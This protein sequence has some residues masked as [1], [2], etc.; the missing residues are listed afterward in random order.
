[1]TAIRNEGRFNPNTTLIDAELF[2]LKGVVA[3]FLIESGDQKILIDTGAKSSGAV[4]YRKLKKLNAWP[5]NKIILTHSH[6]DHTQGVI[7]LRE[8]AEEEGFNIEVMASEKGIQYLKNQKYNTF[9]KY[10]DQ[11]PFVNINK[12]KPLRDGDVIELSDEFHLKIFETPGHMVDDICLYDKQNKCVFV[13]DCVG[14]KQVD[15]FLICNANSPHWDEKAYHS[16]VKKLKTLN[17]ETLC[18]SHFGCITGDEAKSFLDESL[19]IF[20]KWKG[21]FEENSDKLDDIPFLEKQL[22]EKVYSHKSK[23]FREMVGLSLQ[24]FVKLAVIGYRNTKKSN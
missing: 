24:N 3:C 10:E 20:D 12:V 4:I 21:I 23:S 9:F 1:M 6:F 8:K 13:G 2:G 11:K 22:W 14:A 19:V 7:F 17:F 15:S 16:S 5:V 18:L